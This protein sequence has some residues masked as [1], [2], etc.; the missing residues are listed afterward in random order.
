[1]IIFNRDSQEEFINRY[2]SE[3]FQSPFYTPG[4]YLKEYKNEKL[5]EFSNFEFLKLG[6]EFHVI[7]SGGFGDVFLCK[8]NINNKYYAIKQVSFHF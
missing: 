8:N 4:E 1:L 7:G 6:E 2:K 3:E 5:F